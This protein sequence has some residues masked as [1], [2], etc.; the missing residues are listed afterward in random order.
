NDLL[1]GGPMPSGPSTETNVLN[2]GA[3]NDTLVGNGNDSMSGGTGNDTYLVHFSAVTL[4][5][6]GT[7][8]DVIDMSTVPFGVTVDLGLQSGTPQVVNAT[9]APGSTLALNGSFEQLTGTAFGDKLTASASGETLFGGLGNDTLIAQA[10]SDV[11][12]F[13]GDGVDSL[14]AAG[15]SHVTPFGGTGE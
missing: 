1:V 13:G 11:T 15:G 9:A 14:V 12:L 3:G 7:G 8:T 10:G 5:E 2:A 4:T 6:S